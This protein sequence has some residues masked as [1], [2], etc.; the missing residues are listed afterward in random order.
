MPIIVN[1][2]EITDEAVLAEMQHH[3]APTKEDAHVAAAQALVIRELLT[4][5]AEKKGLRA[6][7][8]DQAS[9][10]DAIFKLIEAE[11]TAPEADEDFCRRYYEQNKERF[12]AADADADADEDDLY[13]PFDGVHEKIRDYLHTQS[14]R[15]GV[16]AYIFALAQ[17]AK[18]AGFDLAKMA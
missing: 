11:V 16:R 17:D 13:V 5:E 10:D 6:K 7:D 3:P 2:V 8:S 18:I 4:Q 12:K 1:S 14:V 9:D 15:E